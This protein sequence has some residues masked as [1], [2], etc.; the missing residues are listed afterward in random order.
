MPLQDAPYT[1]EDEVFIDLC[2]EHIEQLTDFRQKW[3]KLLI[4]L[5]PS[6]QNAEEQNKEQETN[7]RAEILQKIRNLLSELMT[8]YLDYLEKISPAFEPTLAKTPWQNWNHFAHN[9]G[10]TG[11]HSMTLQIEW[12]LESEE[13][14]E[15]MKIYLENLPYFI[16]QTICHIQC[17]LHYIEEQAG[18]EKAEP[19]EKSNV[20]AALQTTL[21]SRLFF[22]PLYIPTVSDVYR[23]KAPKATILGD[24]EIKSTIPLE[25][26]TELA[27]IP[28]SNAH[29]IMAQETHPENLRLQATTRETEYR[30]EKLLILEFFNTGKTVD[31]AALQAK[32]LEIPE[33][34]IAV[35][36]PDLIPIIRAIKKGSR[37]A[38]LT[39]QEDVLIIDGLTMTSGGTGIGLNDLHRQLELRSGTLLLNNVYHPE[40][41]FCVTIILPQETGINPNRIIKILRKL[42]EELQTGKYFLPK[43]ESQAA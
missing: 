4:T 35:I 1:H 27:Y 30:G 17:T 5:M 34:K 12:F 31:I 41:G 2:R 39:A 13:N 11:I 19:P 10:P 23:T 42:K 18:K 40:K 24:P 38:K 16:E 21:R 22:G 37:Q 9:I 36:S 28:I 15:E 25:Q 33:T 6:L 7:Q 8:T 14:F 20:I 32:L 26:L 43:V 3:E 29:R